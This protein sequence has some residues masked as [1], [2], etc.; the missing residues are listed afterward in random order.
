MNNWDL[1]CFG[2][3]LTLVY[4]A[5]SLEWAHSLIQ[6]QITAM[7]AGSNTSINT[8]T[9]HDVGNH[10]SGSWRV[11]RMLSNCCTCWPPWACWSSE[12]AERNNPERP[13]IEQRIT[14]IR[15][16]PNIL[17]KNIKFWD[18]LMTNHPWPQ[19][20]SVILETSNRHCFTQFGQHYD[21]I[22]NLCQ[23]DILSGS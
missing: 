15:T 13:D 6:H 14:E 1:G 9:L 3:F 12:F 22:S 19:M 23:S 7:R 11:H 8:S 18:R 10:P 5:H 16:I 20:F 4:A 21:D 2:W 17:P